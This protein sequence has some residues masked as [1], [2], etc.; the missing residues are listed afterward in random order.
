MCRLKKIQTDT[1]TES[2]REEFKRLHQKRNFD[3]LEKPT[4]NLFNVEEVQMQLPP[5][6]KIEPSNPC[7]HCGEPVMASK[8][9]EV[10][11]LMICRGCQ[12]SL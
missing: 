7:E 3:I 11:G 9:T 2:E 1:A 8:L 5:K 12:T 4:E 6:A 10:N